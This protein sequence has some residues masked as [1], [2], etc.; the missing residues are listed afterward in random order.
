MKGF[1]KDGKFRPTGNKSKSSLKKDQ[2]RSK[3][4]S[5]KTGNAPR[6]EFQMQS[7]LTRGVLPSSRFG[8]KPIHG[9]ENK[10]NKKLNEEQ[11]QLGRA[12]R[13]RDKKSLELGKDFHL[14]RIFQSDDNDRSE[15]AHVKAKNLED[16]VEYV[17]NEYLTKEGRD[18]V[19][20]QDGGED[21]AYLMLYENNEDEIKTE[22]EEEANKMEME[23]NWGKLGAKGSTDFWKTDKEKEEWIENE[24]EER[25]DMDEG[26]SWGYEIAQDDDIEENFDTIY[27]SNDFVDLL[28]PERSG[29]KYSDVVKEKGGADKAFYSASGQG[30]ESGNPDNSF[31]LNTG[32]LDL[33]DPKTNP[34]PTGRN[35][36]TKDDADKVWRENHPLD[37]VVR[38]RENNQVVWEQ[39]Y[40]T[41][42]EAVKA[43]KWHEKDHGGAVSIEEEEQ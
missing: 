23:S 6:G 10:L 35:K 26:Y 39:K 2:I 12:D 22:V 21:T 16:A 3:K 25:L 38:V 31:N 7:A 13:G 9:D 27:G 24:V 4:T 42:K 30:F 33:Y 11:M 29:K 15:I 43:R 20:E 14:F 17:K 41:K 34:K 36:F 18:E 1:I 28:D 5:P 8:S 37:Y 40:K 19:D 32:K